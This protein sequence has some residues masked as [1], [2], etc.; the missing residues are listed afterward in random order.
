VSC[1]V[2]TGWC[3]GRST[4]GGGWEGAV[5]EQSCARA[6]VP[7]EGQWSVRPRRD[8]GD[9]HVRFVRTASMPRWRH[10]AGLSHPVSRALGWQH[11][12]LAAAA[13]FVLAG[14]QNPGS[15]RRG[16]EPL[17]CGLPASRPSLAAAALL[18]EESEVPLLFDIDGEAS[19]YPRSSW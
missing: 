9:D 13:G 10:V 19:G 1:E 4:S 3:G 16:D 15:Q 11:P 5:G 8:E 12:G 17:V 7:A 14:P 18:T 2:E 6:P